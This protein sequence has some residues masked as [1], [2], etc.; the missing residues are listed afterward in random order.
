MAGYKYVR[1]YAVSESKYIYP[2]D[3]STSK[4]HA[5]GN[6]SQIDVENLDF[7]KFPEA[8]KAKYSETILGP[9]EVLFIPQ[10]CWHYVRSLSPSFSINFWFER[11]KK[12]N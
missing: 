7:S 6:V 4:I 9:G 5:Q 11:K 10:E 2:S 12:K 8:Q 3:P 1:L